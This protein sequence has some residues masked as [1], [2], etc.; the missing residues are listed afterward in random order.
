MAGKKRL[1][2]GITVTILVLGMVALA[3]VGCGGT[4]TTT[5]PPATT[6]TTSAPA[7][8]APPA[9]TATT[10]PATTTT[11]AASTNQNP[12]GLVFFDKWKAPTGA[13]FFAE[14]SPVAS[15]Q[16]QIAW[17]YGMKEMA[18]LYGAKFTSTDAN[19]SSTKQ[20]ADLDT[21]IQ[22]GAN[23]ITTW[24]LDQGAATA[25]YKK[26]QEA[27]I[28]LIGQASPGDYVTTAFMP[29]FMTTD[30]AETDAAKWI[31]SVT[32]GA[33]IFVI[34]GPPV[35]YIMFV[36]A[37]MEVEAKAAG[38]TVLARQDNLTDQADGAQK[39]VSDLL[40]K[41][42]DVQAVWCFN[43]RSSLGASAAVRAAGKKIYNAA[44]P[45]AGAVFVTGMNGTQE[46][47]EAVRAGITSA[48]YSGDSEKIGAAVI[49]E[50]QYIATGKLTKD[51][52]PYLVVTPWRRIDGTNAAQATFATD[53]KIEKGIFDELLKNNDPSSVDAYMAFLK[54]L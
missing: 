20:I 54:T 35:P 53:T 27:G 49:E 17:T 31:A 18:A 41:Y 33:K 2:I 46:A 30:Q 29:A 22:Q 52:I 8:T 26:V 1:F 48:T 7:T 40:T 19:L 43:D 45:E 25:E 28:P 38:L 23:G 36:T 6:A 9:T 39:I 10:A 21:F 50:L 3:A 4:T 5:A 15:N 47:I 51:Q 11:A 13:P 44:K 37:A 12:T 32:P 24:T 14:C 42:P 34:G 16:H